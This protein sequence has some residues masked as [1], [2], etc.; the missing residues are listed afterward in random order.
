MIRARHKEIYRL[1]TYVF[2]P[3]QP[4]A[5]IE[6]LAFTLAFFLPILQGAGFPF[7]NSAFT[8]LQ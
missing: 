1:I 8:K 2:V 4:L 3:L 7:V 6:E 5:N